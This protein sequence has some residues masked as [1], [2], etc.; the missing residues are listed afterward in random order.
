MNE[1][2]QLGRRYYTPLSNKSFLTESHVMLICIGATAV[3][4]DSFY[5]VLRLSEVVIIPTEV[6]FH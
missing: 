4:V 2:I 3:S 1:K 5:E 6:C